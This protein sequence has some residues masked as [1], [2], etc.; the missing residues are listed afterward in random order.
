MSKSKDLPKSHL[1]L[2]TNL[3]CTLHD[4]ALAMARK[5][6]NRIRGH[7]SLADIRALGEREAAEGLMEMIEQRAG[8][9]GIELLEATEYGDYCLRRYT[10]IGE[11][12]QKP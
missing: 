7:S 8:S 6:Q 3:L 1:R 5:A 11:R 9:L 12:E 4:D 10:E 2:I